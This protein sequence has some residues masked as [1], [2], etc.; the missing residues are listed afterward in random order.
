MRTKNLILEKKLNFLAEVSEEELF[1]HFFLRHQKTMIKM[2]NAVL[3]YT[4]D[5]EVLKFAADILNVVDPDWFKGEDAIEKSKIK[6]S[7][8]K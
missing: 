7:K 2:C 4:K 1:N 8:K 6:N 5:R 3:G